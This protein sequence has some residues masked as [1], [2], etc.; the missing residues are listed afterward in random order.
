MKKFLAIILSVI[1]VFSI[2]PIGLFGITASA[3][4]YGYYTFGA[5]KYGTGQNAITDVNTSISGD[6]VIPTELGY[7]QNDYYGPVYQYQINEIYSINP[8]RMRYCI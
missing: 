4:T 2:C 5:V 1:L 3:E 8:S 7:Y 6:V